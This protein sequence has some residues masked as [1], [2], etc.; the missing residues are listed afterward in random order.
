MIQCNEISQTVNE[1]LIAFQ[2]CNK[3]KNEDL[4]KL[5]ELVA[6]VNT[7]ANGGAR[8]DT[9]IQEVY[10][11]VSDQV[12]TYPINTFHSISVM[13]TNGSITQTINSITVSYP[14]GSVL[15]NTVTTLNQTSFSFKV[16]AGATVVVEY[17]I[18]TL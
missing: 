2:D 17:L 6:A 14:K 9:M 10:Q 18:P 4:R 12:V 1:L 15:N 8:Y 16:K 7:C 13:V 5:T 11:P 3:I